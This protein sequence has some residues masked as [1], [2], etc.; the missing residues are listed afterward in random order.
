MNLLSLLRNPQ[1]QIKNTDENKD[2]II[3]NKML[4]TLTGRH[5]F[6]ATGMHIDT[7]ETGSKGN[8]TFNKYCWA[9]KLFSFLKI[10][11]LTKRPTKA[12]KTETIN[13][14]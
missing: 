14:Q 11:T 13:A 4:T 2:I 12:N 10:Y 5:N 1:N 8:I 7:I 6:I 3:V 9:G